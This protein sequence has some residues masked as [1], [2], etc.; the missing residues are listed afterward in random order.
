MRRLFKKTCCMV[1]ALIVLAAMLTG[2]GSSGTT[3]TKAP[4]TTAS[5]QTAAEET[6]A[7]VEPTDIS[8]WTLNR[9]DADYMNSVIQNINEQNPDINVEYEIYT[10]NFE[11]AVEMAFATNEAPD[12]LF[13]GGS[14]YAK[15]IGQGKYEPLDQYLTPEMK[16][17]FG[18]DAFLEGINMYEG[19]IYSLP[20]IGT[21]ARLIYN[22]DIFQKAGITEVPKTVEQMA[23]TAITISEKLKGEGIY[24]FAQNLKSPSSGFN[25]SI[26]FILMRSGGNY[27]G[28]DYKTASYDFMPYKP[29][30]EAYT[31]IFTSDAAFPGCESLDIDP[32]RSQFANGK[33]G[34]YIS[35]THS[36]PG[37]YQDQFPTTQNWDVAQ[38]PTIDGN[39]NGSQ[40]MLLAGRWHLMTSE[41]KNKDKAWTVMSGLYSDEVLKGYH[42]KGLGNVTIQSVLKQITNQPPT[43]AK[44]PNLA[45]TENDKLWPPAPSDMTNIVPEGKAMYDVFAEI[46]FGVETDID[47][48]LKDL[49]DR[50]NKALKDAIASGAAKEIKYPDFDPKNP[51]AVFK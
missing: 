9:H 23:Q 37:V 22:K 41:S 32:L 28:Y 5:S 51:A 20:A 2:C 17:H 8:I 15:Y 11:Q 3:D 46:I 42:E 16:A 39:V 49:T 12:I 24:G 6:K 43:I 34:M 29:I 7:P 48:T 36:E 35:W 38:L 27:R 30:L 21:T 47:G 33:I 40:H 4:S 50:Y 19:K 45:F 25:R 44:M 18:D 1:L 14:I 13:D 26:D 31:K 10:E